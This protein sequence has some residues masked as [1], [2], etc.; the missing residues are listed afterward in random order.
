M[1]KV[2]E[3]E[4]A[5]KLIDDIVGSEEGILNFLM[6]EYQTRLS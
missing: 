1:E 4:T 2:K 3:E 5:E 6:Q